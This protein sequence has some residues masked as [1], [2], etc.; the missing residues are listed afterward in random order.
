MDADGAE[1]EIPKSIRRRRICVHL[2]ESAVRNSFHLRT[3]PRPSMFTFAL[4]PELNADRPPERRGVSR[5]RVRLL[6]INRHTGALTHTRFNRLT[7]FLR[8]HDLLVFNSSHTLPAVLTA[9]VR[10]TSAQI[11][12]RLAERLANGDWLV[13]LLGQANQNPVV[14]ERSILDFGQ[15][16]T[17]EVLG[18][19]QA[20][21]RL[22][23]VRFSAAGTTFVDLIY[24]LGQPVRY[25]Y[26]AAPWRLSY[27]Q[28]VYAQ[29]PGSSEMP[30]AGRAFSWQ[31]LF[32]LRDMGVQTANIILHTGLSSYM[33]GELDRQHL[34]SEEEY[35]IPEDAAEKIRCAQIEGGRIIAV[36][37]TV[38]RALEA[39]LVENQGSIRASHSYTRLRISDRHPL[40]LVNGLITGLHEPAASHLDLLAAFIPKETLFDA[41]AEAIQQRYLWHE[42]GDLNLIV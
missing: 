3:N 30:S 32:Q 17:A 11:E 26:L 10:H 12:V 36:G 41:Y 7:E 15:G 1:L 25:R 24:R 19:D 28:N 2:R 27:Y 34:M 6:V 18:P 5:D 38:V 29:I 22:W 23:C 33:D 4:P 31:L 13:L 9:T 20:I 37:T 8:P 39:S 21:S 35:W 42:F 16:L 14:P 40:R